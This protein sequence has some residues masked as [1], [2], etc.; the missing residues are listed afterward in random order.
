M[1]PHGSEAHSSGSG[2]GL[3]ARPESIES[4]YAAQES[5]LLVYAQKL[6]NQTETAEDIVQEAFL[7]LHA[8]FD[9]VRQPKAWL[10]RTVHNLALN[11]IRRN[12]KV[13]PLVTSESEEKQIPDGKP[14]PDEYLSRI[15][16]IGHTRLCLNSLDQRSRELIRLK[17][18]EG[19]S[20]K[21]IS[22]RTHLTISNVGYL[23]HH[24]LKQVGAA[25][26]K[27]G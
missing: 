11:Q 12:R 25:L 9:A 3:Q 18:E 2:S 15:E 20:Y 27:E 24:A 1:P 10:Y 17:F 4:I 13:V 16:A 26:G 8:D 22:Q 7:K 21:E 14:L 5:A 19:L 23:L 6:V